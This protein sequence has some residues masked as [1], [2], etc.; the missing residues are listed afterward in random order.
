MPNGYD[1]ALIC[2]NG[3]VVNDHV[4]ESPYRNTKY[5]TRCGE[6][7]IERCPHC[8]SG[9]RGH[10][11]LVEGFLP[12][13]AFCHECGMPYPWT[14]LKIQAARNLTKSMDKLS[15]SEKDILITSIDEI[16]RDTPNAVTAAIQ[17]KSLLAKAG[18]AVA[19]AMRDVLIDIVSE[20]AKK[21]VW[22]DSK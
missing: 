8:K 12:T 14:L 15:K 9:I 1:I 18:K 11:Y 6:S 7:T 22:P 21:I 19:K 2:M 16:V 20:A 10:P 13:P 5:C 17:Y 3:H 4:K